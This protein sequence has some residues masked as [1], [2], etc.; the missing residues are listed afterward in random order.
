MANCEGTTPSSV[1]GASDY[2]LSAAAADRFANKVAMTTYPSP[3]EE[4]HSEEEGA[5]TQAISLLLP[6]KKVFNRG[7]GER[8]QRT[9]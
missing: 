1:S 7:G 5:D 8:K 4:L 3:E 9:K 6:P 2:S